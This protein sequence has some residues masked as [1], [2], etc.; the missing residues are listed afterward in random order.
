MARRKAQNGTVQEPAQE[1]EPETGP[2]PGLVE[3][4]G[5]AQVVARTTV[6]DIDDVHIDQ[7]NVR[8]HDDRNLS[9]IGDSLVQFG[10][11]RSIVL[12]SRNIV[13]AG[14]GTV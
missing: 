8:I 3:S 6:V 4:Q 14:N 2:G 12:D 1:P 11:A 13:R 10:P 5:Q 9:V 7:G